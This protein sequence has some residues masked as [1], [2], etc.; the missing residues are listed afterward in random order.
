VLA[1]LAVLIGGIVGWTAAFAGAMLW[2][3]ALGALVV[4][5]VVAV[6]ARHQR[7]PGTFAPMLGW[8]LAFTPLT[9]PLLWLAVGLTRYLITGQMLG[10]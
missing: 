4:I 9:W 7:S 5:A 3:L 10:N 8:S 2:G 1:L 6:L